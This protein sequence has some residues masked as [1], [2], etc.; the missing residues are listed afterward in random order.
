MNQPKLN[1]AHRAWRCLPSAFRRNAMSGIASSL[2]RKP[3]AAP[4]QSS[5]SIIVAGDI[6]GSNGL[7]ASARI[8]HD[9]IAANGLSAGMVPL[10]LPSVVPAFNGVLPA[11]AALLAVVN[12]PILPVGLLRLPRATLA[13][14]RVIGLWA[15]EL[16]AVPR[17]WRFGAKFAHEIW[18]PSAFTAAAL[19]P[20]APGRV[21][22][23]PYPL[24]AVELPVEGNRQDFG[25]PADALVV[26]TAVNLASSP[27]RKNPLAAIAA[28]KAAFGARPDCI[29]VLKLSGLEACGD[30]LR[31]IRAA[32]GLAP[33]IRLLVGTMPEPRL[34]GLI[35]A[36][37]I[38]LSLHRSEGFGLIPAT[39]ML[40]GRPVVATGWSGN[41]TFMNAGNA[42]LVDYRLVPASDARGVYRVKGAHWAEPDITHAA[43]LLRRLADDPAQRA[44]LAAAGQRHATTTLGAAPLLA[45]L[46]ENG[47][48]SPAR[49]YQSA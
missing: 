49:S 1:M 33:N 40:L 3:D 28:F 48:S 19:E 38:V 32:I 22:V 26:L 4:P 30:A 23:V 5:Q 13:G 16:P 18:A 41:L 11:N 42:A 24:A 7:A 9:V 45:A 8:V 46:G 20:L 10:G 27:E 15:W 47:I 12:A 25:L 44:E 36:S 34:R 29:F 2:A 37:D 43:F 21:R 17:Q 6:D 14:R 35:A 31:A 39:A